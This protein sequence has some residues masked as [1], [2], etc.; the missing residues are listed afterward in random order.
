SGDDG[1][2]G[3]FGL[4]YPPTTSSFVDTTDSFAMAQ[5]SKI[6]PEYAINC[7]LTRFDTSGIPDDAEIVSANL[8]L[9][10]TYSNQ[11]DA[12]S[13][14]TLEW[15]D[16]A[17]WPIDIG[18]YTATPSNSAGW[19]ALQGLGTGVKE[20]ALSGPNAYVNKTGYTGLRMHIETSGTPTGNNR[21]EFTTVD[22]G[23]APYLKI[24]YKTGGVQYTI[25]CALVRFDTAALPDTAIISGATLKLKIASKADADAAQIG[26]EWYAGANWP[27]DAADY[28]ATPGNTAWGYTALSSLP[29]VGQWLNVP[30]FSPNTN[31]NKTGY[32]GFR[33][34]IKTTGTPTGDNVVSFASQE[35]AD[36]PILQ[37][38]YVPGEMIVG[39]YEDTDSQTAYG[40]FE[41]QVV[42]P[43]LLSQ[44]EAEQQ[45]ES[46]VIVGAWPQ[47]AF[48]TA[49][50]AH[51]L[52]VGQ[53]V[54]VI[55]PSLGINKDFLIRRLRIGGLGP[56]TLTY[57]IDCGDFRDDLI[58]HLRMM[59]LKAARTM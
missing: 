35:S 27:I 17:N 56:G 40:L 31:I 6:P 11:A 21:V 38:T 26:V 52:A 46:E 12:Y 54:H 1:H 57:S 5:R 14:F 19:E 29:A 30:L 42:N 23:T 37:V 28:T 7:A 15:Y 55:F 41:K 22:G 16:A 49:I 9:N 39:T 8:V 59:A 50:L 53:L 10:V 44:A 18:D 33:V 36:D 34:H 58:R 3:M 48:G 32:T 45:A 47:Y 43:R 13:Y 51:G 24:T 20:F 2:V 4:S 25:S